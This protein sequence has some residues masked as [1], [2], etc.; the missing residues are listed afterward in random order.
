MGGKPGL[1]IAGGLYHVMLTEHAGS[2]IL[3]KGEDF[4]HLC[5]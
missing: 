4:N 5:P 2:L 3:K 1:H